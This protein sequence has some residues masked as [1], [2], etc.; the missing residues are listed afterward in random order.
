MFS[1]RVVIQNDAFEKKIVELLFGFINHIIF[2]ILLYLFYNSTVG[3]EAVY[4]FLT[5]R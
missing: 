4:I 5:N 3:K 2:S 1:K